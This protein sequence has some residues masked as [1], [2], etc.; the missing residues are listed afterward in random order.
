MGKEDPAMSMFNP[1][2]YCL[3]EEYVP[4]LEEYQLERINNLINDF[5]KAN[6]DCD[7][8]EI[9]C[10][11][12]CG[13]DHPVLTKGGMSGSGKQM[14][15]CSECRSRFVY[16]TGSLT[17]YSHQSPS[18]WARFIEMTISKDS[19]EDCAVVLHIHVSTAFRMRHKLMAFLRMT[20]AN[21]SI[22]GLCEIDET[23]IHSDR[24]GLVT[25]EI[26]E[27]YYQIFCLSALYKRILH[28]CG[29]QMAKKCTEMINQINSEIKILVKKGWKEKRENK[30]RGISRDL[31]CIFTGIERQG[32]S[33]Y[34]ASNLGKPNQ[35]E[36]NAFVSHVEKGS[37]VWVDGLQAYVPAL[38]DKGCTYKVCP[39]KED[40]TA[41]DHLNNVNALHDN[42]KGWIK[43]Y[44]G[45]SAIY[46]NRYA[47]MISYIY[48]HRSMEM[49]ELRTKMI[50]DLNTH[51]LYFR[52]N[53]I[54]YKDVFIATEDQVARSG[55]TSMAILFQQQDTHSDTRV[56]VHFVSEASQIDIPC[57]QI[58]F[59]YKFRPLQ[60]S[61]FSRFSGEH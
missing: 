45:I 47:N 60:F 51:Q 36:V 59:Q 11:P 55:L 32:E 1:D 42:F 5:I 22:S 17:F 33:V 58:W 31:V 23:Y 40:Y 8:H 20:Q 34:C 61:V 29:E 56:S 21:D 53:D 44:R 43:A 10:C 50:N 12:K 14:L 28:V 54:M 27:K 6:R 46:S 4:L 25:P 9:E 48:D 2:Y 30:K 38:E 3:K 37:H 19:L 13:V 7:T 24:K 15:Q 57:L 49:Q 52:V 35:E 26:G 39:T 18:K 16:D 41:L